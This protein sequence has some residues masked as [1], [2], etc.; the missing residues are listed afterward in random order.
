[1]RFF[2]LWV[3]QLFCLL[4]AYTATT[5]AKATPAVQ[6]GGQAAPASTERMDDFVQ[7][8]MAAT[9]V[10]GIAYAIVGPA[11]ILHTGVFGTDGNG[12]LV[13]PATPF[14]WGSLAKPVAA[15][16]AMTL[17]TSGEL[18]LDAPVTTY[19][20]A[21]RLRDAASRRITIRH[22]LNH[23]SGIPTSVELTDRFVAD[24][25]P[26][27]VLP[28]LAD[29]AMVSTP[30]AEYH[31]ASTNY[32]VL[33]AVIEAVTGQPFAAVLKQRVL[34][35]LGMASMITTSA[36]ATDRLPPG[37]RF[38]FGQAVAFPTPFD[39]AG[40]AYGYLGG[41][42]TD[43]VAFAQANLGGTPNVL[44]AKQRAL[45]FQ[46]G[47]TTSGD[48]RYGLGWRR[49]PLAEFVADSGD[50]LIWHG[51]AAPGYQAMILLLPG[52]EQAVVVL[53]N[54]YGFFQEPRLLDTAFG[55]VRLLA[56]AAP[57]PSAAG[58]VYPATL[59][60]LVGFCLILVALVARSFWVLAYPQR[61]KVA[62]THRG[63]RLAGWL[64]A[65][66]VVLYGFGVF[67][68]SYFGVG[69]AQ[70]VLWAPDVAWLV[71]AVLVLAALLL[72]LRIAVSIK[73]IRGEV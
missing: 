54:A 58:L 37:H 69:L 71:Y 61:D 47:V 30:G 73:L 32:L 60:G 23:S 45:M 15:T 4:P 31:Y 39:P 67:L 72:V 38:V 25:Q 43:A 8:Q 62:R 48:H 11:G 24:R 26:A 12:Q 14:L 7:D 51:G 6:P 36:A 2:R 13:T 64:V 5:A 57:S 29:V 56:G 22:L 17:V 46:G 19:L 53:Q 33:A 1:M 66:A 10:P 65:L 41:T 49:W 20:P 44:N 35:P 63:V 59:A 55:L 40:V 50:D 52:Q 9:G 28:A 42:L 18:Q 34:D 16:L 3:G 68:P 70:I 27:D 21:F